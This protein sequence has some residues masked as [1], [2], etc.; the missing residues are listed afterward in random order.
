MIGGVCDRYGENERCIW[1]F[2]G[3]NLKARYYSEDLK[4]DVRILL[5]WTRMGG[6]EWIHVAHDK[7]KRRAPVSAVIN[8]RVS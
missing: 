6:V 1:C 3:G 8:L 4:V 5:K 2:G 7:D